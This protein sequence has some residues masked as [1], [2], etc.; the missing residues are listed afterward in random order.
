MAYDRFLIAPM[1]SG[2]RTDLKPW[3]I[4]DDAFAQLDNVY[5]FRG[6]IKKRFGSRLT[7]YGWTSDETAPL[8]SRLRIAVRDGGGALKTTD[9]AGA[10]AGFALGIASATFGFAVGQAFSIGDEIFTV[11]TAGAVQPMLATGAS[12]VHTFSTT[13]GAYN[14]TG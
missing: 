5:L 2:L 6:R 11:T 7:G 13:D 8:Y 4:P 9:G 1:K 12:V 10:A 3:M 14:F